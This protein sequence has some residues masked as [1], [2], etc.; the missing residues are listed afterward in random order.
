MGSEPARGTGFVFAV[1]FRAALLALLLCALCYVLWQTRYYATALVVLLGS[2]LVVTDL[3]LLIARH[4]RANERFL[5]ALS[6]GALETPMQRS[7][8]PPA[9]RKAYDH[10]LEGIRRDRQQQQQHSQYLQ[11]LLDTVPAGLL[12]LAEDEQVALVNR[13]AHRLLGEG[14]GRLDKVSALGAQGVALLQSLAPGTHRIV[15]LANGRR[16]LASAARFITPG[17]ASRRLISLQRLA[18][19]LDAVELNAWD[20]MA[21]VLAHE[22]MNSLTPIASLS[23]SLDA[24]LREGGRA[25]DVAEALETITRRSQGLLR[26]VERYRKVADLPEPQLRVLPLARLLD[27]VERLIRP[28]LAERGIALCSRVTPPELVI[29]ADSDLLEQALINLLRNAADAAAE[30]DGSRIEVDCCIDNERCVIEV[31]DNGPGLTAEQRAQIFVPFYTTKPGGSG[32]GLALA[33]RIAQGHG[34]RITLENNEP[35][36][37]LFRLSLPL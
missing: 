17:D 10:L 16:L 14:A 30:S 11:T 19:D 1:L 13:A 37:S 33:R 31:R 36:G 25:Q 24:L 22:M 35:R 32:I 27:G 8:I 21:R 28:A 15:Q 26:F 2:A 5:E 7:A 20:D 3:V 23:Q 4:N 9:L 34:G 6:A 12:V 29:S 18:G